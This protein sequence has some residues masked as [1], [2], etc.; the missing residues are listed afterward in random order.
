MAERFY[1]LAEFNSQITTWIKRKTE[2]IFM[3]NNNS[4]SNDQFALS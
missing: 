1:N 4:K 3:T 2:F